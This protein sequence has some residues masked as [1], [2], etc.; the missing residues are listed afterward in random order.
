MTETSV[1]E[2]APTAEAGAEWLEKKFYSDTDVDFAV[3]A[4]IASW[5]ARSERVAELQAEVGY[6]DSIRA[7]AR[8][9]A[10]EE[11]EAIARR[12]AMVNKEAFLRTAC[13]GETL[14]A[15]SATADAIADAISALAA[16]D[17][18]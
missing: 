14:E 15:C 7:L 12:S 16:K 11:A 2:I 9:K 1:K 13:G 3:R 17:Q 5:R 18:P 6:S 8:K 4:L 10:L